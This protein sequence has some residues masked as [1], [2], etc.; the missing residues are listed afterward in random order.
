MCRIR[1]YSNQRPIRIEAARENP[2]QHKPIRK[3]IDSLAF[4][5][6]G[7]WVKK[8][9]GQNRA[10]LFQNSQKM[11]VKQANIGL[12]DLPACKLEWDVGE[13]ESD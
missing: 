13:S 9:E 12:V 6:Y 11:D 8:G 7:H 3:V 1:R 5:I 4:G 10:A 2:Y